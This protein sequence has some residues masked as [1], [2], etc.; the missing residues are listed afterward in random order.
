MFLQ[1][2]SFL[3][4]VSINPNRRLAKAREWVVE[5]GKMVGIQGGNAELSGTWIRGE[6]VGDVEIRVDDGRL[7]DLFFVLNLV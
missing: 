3:G 5:I 2:I 6:S 7:V 4:L 1:T